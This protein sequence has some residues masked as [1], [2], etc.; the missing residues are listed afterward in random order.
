[1]INHL[2]G[3]FAVFLAPWHLPVSMTDS[4][5]N[6]GVHCFHAA[7]PQGQVS[8]SVSL[9]ISDTD[10]TRTRSLEDVITGRR[11]LRCL[12][13]RVTVACFTAV[14]C[15]AMKGRAERTHNPAFQKDTE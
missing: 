6:A 11:S 7:S 13:E 8:L 2:T 1:M 4:E 9:W 5:Y 12:R 10:P 15:N 3:V 14:C